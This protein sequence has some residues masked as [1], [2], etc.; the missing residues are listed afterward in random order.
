MDCEFRA[1]VDAAR[2]HSAD[3]QFSTSAA[4]NIPF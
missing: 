4:Q 3:A 1:K 2:K